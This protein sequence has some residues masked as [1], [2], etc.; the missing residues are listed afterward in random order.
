MK[1]LSLQEAGVPIPITTDE[2]RALKQYRTRYHDLTCSC[3]HRGRINRQKYETTQT[4][5][6]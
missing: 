5:W 1:S 3:D 6:R 2:L 4:G